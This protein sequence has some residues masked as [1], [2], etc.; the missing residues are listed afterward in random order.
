[1]GGLFNSKARFQR[2]VYRAG[3]RTALYKVLK[4]H[5]PQAVGQVVDG[6][7]LLEELY[8]PIPLTPA[9]K[10]WLLF[11]QQKRR[12]CEVC[13]WPREG[14]YPGCEHHPH[15]PKVKLCGSHLLVRE[16]VPQS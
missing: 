5:D 4:C 11:T 10:T 3:G 14:R 7:T 15:Q 2:W 9:Y 8:I 6:R 1:V 16:S 13:F 12:R